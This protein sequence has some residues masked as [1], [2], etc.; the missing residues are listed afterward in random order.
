MASKKNVVTISKL[1]KARTKLLELLEKQ[2]YDI[3]NYSN[4]SINNL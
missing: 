2:G 3:E 4:F 1:Y